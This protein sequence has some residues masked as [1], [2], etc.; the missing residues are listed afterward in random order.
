MWYGTPIISPLEYELPGLYIHYFRLPLHFIKVYGGSTVGPV[1]FSRTRLDH[2]KS[3]AFMRDLLPRLFLGV[4][5]RPLA[6]S[7]KALHKQI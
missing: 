7:T 6:A 2:D 3:F 1:P 4:A 5:V